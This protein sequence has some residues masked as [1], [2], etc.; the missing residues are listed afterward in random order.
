MYEERDFREPYSFGHARY[1][2]DDRRAQYPLQWT[3]Y[4]VM[5]LEWHEGIAER[6]GLGLL[7]QNAVDFSLAP[8]P[9]WKEIFL[10]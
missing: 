7:H 5:L 6:R 10:A 2:P 9:T 3:F 8:G 4:Y 1:S